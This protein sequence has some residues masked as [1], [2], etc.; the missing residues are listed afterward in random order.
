MKWLHRQENTIY[1]LNIQKLL[2]QFEKCWF[3]VYAIITHPTI[4]SMYIPY[5][6]GGIIG[7]IWCG[8]HKIYFVKKLKFN[9]NFKHDFKSLLAGIW[10][11]LFKLQSLVAITQLN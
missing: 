11:L 3:C 1:F 6:H 2:M 4:L 5:I 10:K 8:R 9:S 7:Y